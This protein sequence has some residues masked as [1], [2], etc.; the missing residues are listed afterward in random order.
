MQSNALF[1]ISR[2]MFQYE[3]NLR[4]IYRQIKAKIYKLTGESNSIKFAALN[5]SKL[6]FSNRAKS[7]YAKSCINGTE[8]QQI[9]FTNTP[10]IYNIYRTTWE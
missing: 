9:I 7:C 8:T 4:A 5:F 3:F 10:N 1:F 6:F 2:C